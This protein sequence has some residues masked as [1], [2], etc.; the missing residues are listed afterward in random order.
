M[1]FQIGMEVNISP[2]FSLG[3]DYQNILNRILDE[4]V[5]NNIHLSSILVGFSWR[6]PS[7]K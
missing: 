4:D 6:I 2:E 3:V 5:F 7:G 1:G